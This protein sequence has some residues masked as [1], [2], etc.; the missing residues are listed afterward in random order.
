MQVSVENIKMKKSLF[1]SFVHADRPLF[2][3]FVDKASVKTEQR[4]FLRVEEF[5]QVG[6]QETVLMHILYSFYFESL[7]FLLIFNDKFLTIPQ[8]FF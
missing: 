8:L 6:P 5:A 7:A 3:F 4:M 1:D 2:L